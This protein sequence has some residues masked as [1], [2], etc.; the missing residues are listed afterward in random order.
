MCGKGNELL[1]S[2]C[3][4]GKSNNERV[5]AKILA[6][7]NDSQIIHA[8]SLRRLTENAYSILQSS[9]PLQAKPATREFS[10]P[11]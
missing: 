2:Q 4:A 11:S 9:G 3:V 5:G 8:N 10:P 1:H 7:N 6:Q